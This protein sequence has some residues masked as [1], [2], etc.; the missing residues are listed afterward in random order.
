[1]KDFCTTQKKLADKLGCSAGYL[2]G[3]KKRSI[4]PS[5][6]MAE[7]L[8]RVVG[9]SAYWWGTA[10]QRRVAAEIDAFLRQEREMERTIMTLTNK[11]A[12]A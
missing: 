7:K 9:H 5:E 4:V 3:V 12:A 6:E 10:C 8:S 1:M 11:R 2:S